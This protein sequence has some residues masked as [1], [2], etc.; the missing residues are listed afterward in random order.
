MGALK[1]V[2]EP[3][4]R[5]LTLLLLILRPYYSFVAGGRTP[6]KGSRAALFL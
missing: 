6:K 4:L 2:P 3:P 1:R 5:L